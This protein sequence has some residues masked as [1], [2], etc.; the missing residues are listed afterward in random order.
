MN[1][2]CF[3]SAPANEESMV[4]STNYYVT[5]DSDL[6]IPEIMYEI[7]LEQIKEFS[8]YLIS[9][10]EPVAAITDVEGYIQAYYEHSQ[11]NQDD[12]YFEIFTKL[13]SGMSGNRFLFVNVA[14]AILE[15]GL[16][17]DVNNERYLNSYNNKKLDYNNQLKMN[18]AMYGCLYSKKRQK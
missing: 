17:N 14:I 18:H 5:N 15:K 11:V 8:R 16:K 12:P 10:F 4:L 9:N 6:Y 2:N 13:M 3:Y 1:E 7:D